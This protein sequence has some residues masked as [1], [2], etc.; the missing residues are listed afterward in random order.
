MSKIKM[1]ARDPKL[2]SVA[3]SS[4]EDGMTR[5]ASIDLVMPGRSKQL[6]YLRQIT[7]PGSPRDFVFRKDESTIG[8]SKTCDFVV[9][10]PELSRVHICIRRIGQELDCADNDSR[11]GL[12]LNGI[13]VYSCVLRPGDT[14]QIGNASF[15]FF[16]GR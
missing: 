9:D 7:G 11:N 6:P 15:H 12:Y 16:E 5:E 1:A 8:R 3:E 2:E 13:R 10:S 4:W 14:I